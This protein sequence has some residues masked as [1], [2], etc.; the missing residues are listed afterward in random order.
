MVLRDASASKN[1]DNVTVLT[2]LTILT[3]FILNHGRLIIAV[4][5]LFLKDEFNTIAL[6]YVILF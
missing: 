4:K 6:Y 3:M 5:L 2:I 1:S